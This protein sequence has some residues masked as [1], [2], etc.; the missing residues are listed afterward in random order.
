MKSTTKFPTKRSN[1]LI[2]G[3]FLLFS[4]AVIAQDAAPAIFENSV[5]TSASDANL[6]WGKCPEFMPKG[7][8]IAVLHGDPAKRN[9][10]V[11]FKIPSHYVVP[12]HKHNSAERMIVI[13][14]L[15][16]VQYEGEQPKRIK[17]GSY[18]YGP[19]NKA[20]TAKCIKGPC[21]IFIAFEDPLDAIPLVTTKN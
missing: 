1:V 11:L 6:I 12:N 15:L 16:E 21:V 4:N 10:D 9:V 8:S 2:W 3:L 18:A 19:A 5:I 14:G 7:C 17:A 13:S 20:H